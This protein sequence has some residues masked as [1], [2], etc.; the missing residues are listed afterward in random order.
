METTEQPKAELGTKN[1]TEVV[2]MGLKSY[3]ALSEAKK[4]DGK[5]DFKDIYLVPGLIP[6]FTNALE[7]VDQ[8]VPE[9]KDL[10]VEEMA[11]LVTDVMADLGG[12]EADMKIKIEKVLLALKANYEAVKA[13]M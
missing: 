12:V 1:L 7:G 4:N 5:I 2:I 3:G 10:S 6:Y 11:K 13:F 9:A 8:V